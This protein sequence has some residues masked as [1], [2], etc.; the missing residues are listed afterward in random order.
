MKKVIL[1]TIL[2]FAVGM[3]SMGQSAYIDYG[4]DAFE[5]KDY[6]IAAQF[7]SAAATGDKS[8]LPVRYP[9]QNTI[10]LGGKL[11][12]VQ[13][14]YATNQA[15]TSYRLHFDYNNA[16]A[17][18]EMAFELDGGDTPEN[19]FCYG[20]CLRAQESLD[21]AK[22]QFERVLED[23]SFSS[24][25][26]AEFQLASVELAI[27]GKEHPEFVKISKVSEPGVNEGGSSNYGATMLD[28][29]QFMFTTTR[30]LSKKFNVYLQT[31]QT[32]SDSG[33]V[34]VLSDEKEKQQYAG[35]SYSN[36][37]KRYYFN[38]WSTLD[39]KKLYKIA[40]MNV[41]DEEITILEG[42]T[43][44]ESRDLYPFVTSDGSTLY[45]ASDRAGGAGG[46]DIYKVSLSDDGSASGATQ[47]VGGSIN[48][49]KD[50]VTPYV[51]DAKL[52]FSSDGHPGYGG[53]DIFI[54][55]LQGSDVQNLG[56]PINSTADDA[57]FTKGHHED[58][59][60]LSTD[61]EAG[62][63]LELFEYERFHLF[64]DGKMLEKNT[65][66]AIDSAEVF[67]V[68]SIS[69]DT[70]QS[71]YTDE[72]GHYEFEVGLNQS[73]LVYS[74]K[75]FFSA[76]ST[77]VR[78]GDVSDYEATT[79]LTND[80]LLIYPW[81]F[82]LANVYFDF[83]KA[84]LRPESNITLDSLINILNAYP[85]IRIEIGGHTD[86]IGTDAYNQK[87]S[88]RRA[89]AVVDYL[90]AN[91]IS[92]ERLEAMGYGE[93]MPVAPNRKEDGSDNPDGRALNRRTEFKIAD[94]N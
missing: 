40:F 79:T 84:T 27:E 19:R 9:Y 48:T 62:C 21:S 61:R 26:D 67:L 10:A 36:A 49:S 42:I 23:S 57:Y 20:V 59:F 58:H 63:C 17:Y 81:A 74:S 77:S 60:Y 37:K 86:A 1:F 88:Q 12:K 53:L 54:A 94:K 71:M 22:T 38:T 83:D 34:A 93:S 55:N 31:I 91:G 45:F 4:D 7:Y 69:G 39:D 92:L 25:A 47:S 80:D 14:L 90:I 87:L 6:D 24:S 43:T 35:V 41:D 56:F 78:S 16:A 51:S 52:Y 5:D 33:A 85:A 11:S 82:K 13:K 2:V 65:L 8:L 44:E 73:Y 3:T 18:Y 30:D 46:M 89:Q 75:P 72:E 68:D 64:V 29:G 76:D 32:T 70:L 15:A 28:D 50:E 66:A